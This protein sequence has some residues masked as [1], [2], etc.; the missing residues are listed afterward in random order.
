M[1]MLVFNEAI[2]FKLPDKTRY[3]VS[4][5]VHME[6]QKKRLKLGQNEACIALLA[7]YVS[8]IKD[9][10]KL[11]NQYLSSLTK[12]G[13]VLFGVHIVTNLKI[14]SSWEIEIRNTDKGRV[15]LSLIM[16]SFDTMR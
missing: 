4:A 2:F 7:I 11:R 5:I 14:E 13:L 6:F 15:L 10:M 12:T 3:I 16:Y 8:D 9:V 1:P